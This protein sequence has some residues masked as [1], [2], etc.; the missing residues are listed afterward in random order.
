[1]HSLQYACRPSLVDVLLENLSID[2]IVW[3]SPQYF[4]PG[5][6]TLLGLLGLYRLSGS[7]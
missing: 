2:F 5:G 1:M 6:V 7:P 3:Q 4:V